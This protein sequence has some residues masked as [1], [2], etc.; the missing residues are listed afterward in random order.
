MKNF[1]FSRAIIP[2]SFTALNIFFGFLA[3]VFA[4]KYEV[5]LAVLSVILAAFFDM[6]DGMIARMVKTSSAF[7]VELDSL[8]DVV[9]FGAAP[10]FLIYQIDFH[11]YGVI[12]IALSALPLV[13]GSFRLARFNT[14]LTDINT[15]SDFTGLPIPA[16]ALTIC[17]Y[18]YNFGK[19][20]SLSHY[21]SYILMAVVIL[22]SLLMVSS[23]KY[24]ALPKIFNFK[25]GYKLLLFFILAASATAMYYTN[26]DLLFF[27]F[28]SL[29]LFGILR[30]IFF[31]IIPSKDDD[32]NYNEEIN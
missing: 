27:F 5:E 25:L 9:S 19:S 21:Y 13:L 14:T 30:Y 10:A 12:G 26:G 29:V 32:V 11:N 20:G 7:G 6:V 15:K 23:V 3:I 28:I 17:T 22:V 1:T 16:A 4:S 8:S 24:N 2:N 18:V 31:K